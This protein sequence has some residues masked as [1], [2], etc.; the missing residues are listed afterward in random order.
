MVEGRRAH[1]VH[2]REVT[3]LELLDRILDKGVI[4]AGDV[5]I[6]VADIDLIYLGLKVILT[7]VETLEKHKAR[8][9]LGMGVIVDPEARV[10]DVRCET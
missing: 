10:Q 6:S 5:V 7:S 2:E 9:A 4:I 8:Y 3:L 1:A